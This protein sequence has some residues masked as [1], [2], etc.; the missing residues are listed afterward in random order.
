MEISN[1]Y[2]I[3]YGKN[4][5]FFL[6][7]FSFDRVFNLMLN[8]RFDLWSFGLTF[9][10]SQRGFQGLILVGWGGGPDVVLKTRA[11]KFS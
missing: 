1:V 8:N 4:Y 2:Q 10:R 9:A 6:C 7:C 11:Y 3:R 5:F